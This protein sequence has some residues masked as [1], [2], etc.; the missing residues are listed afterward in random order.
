MSSVLPISQLVLP[1]DVDLFDET[2]WNL[3][4]THNTHAARADA[5]I[6]FLLPNTLTVLLLL[7][8]NA[9]TQHKERGNRFR[10]IR[11]HTNRPLTSIP[12]FYSTITHFYS[13]VQDSGINLRNFT[14]PCQ[15]NSTQSAK[16]PRTNITIYWLT[17]LKKKSPATASRKSIHLLGFTIRDV[18]HAFISPFPHTAQAATILPL[19][20]YIYSIYLVRLLTKIQEREWESNSGNNAVSSGAFS[21]SQTH[22]RIQTH[23][24]LI[25]GA[26]TA[27]RLT[28]TQ[29]YLF[30]W[31][32]QITYH[33]ACMAE[34]DR[35]RSPV[36]SVITDSRLV[37]SLTHRFI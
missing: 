7:A 2:F 30:G 26:H 15:S 18:I 25:S 6:K 4:Q 36:I 21:P 8:H 35:A 24:L 3:R 12:E 14:R 20:R 11:M 34:R 9:E 5:K 28:H 23:H 13:S 31:M 19:R 16:S 37:H 17:L 22:K 33:R 27:A 29:M 1:P 10:K 32:L